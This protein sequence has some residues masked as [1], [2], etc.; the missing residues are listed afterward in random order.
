M[1]SF[2][3]TSEFT[4]RYVEAAFYFLIESVKKPKKE[5]NSILLMIK[6]MKESSKL[7]YEKHKDNKDVHL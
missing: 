3:I 6:I 1:K 2:P 7:F 5:K 4:D